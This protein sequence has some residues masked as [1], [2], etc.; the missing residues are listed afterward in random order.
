MWNGRVEHRAYHPV[1]PDTSAALPLLQSCVLGFGALDTFLGDATIRVAGGE[2]HMRYVIISLCVLATAC[3]GASP[4]APTASLGARS[5]APVTVAAGGTAT[6][7]AQ[8]GA[9]L[10]FK[11]DLTATELVEG[12]QHHLSGTGNGTHL[13]R[14]TYSAD[15]IVVEAT[16]DGTGTAVWTAAN[17]DRITANTSGVILEADF[18]HGRIVVGESQT[19]TG[20]TGRF[21]KASGTIRVERTLD[22]TS[23]AT[24]GHFDGTLSVAH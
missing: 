17:G 21:S 7:L 2:P 15:I 9:E 8:S 24:S 23:G 10:P 6:S 12:S 3:A 14:F 4:T 20:G 11:G 1:M 13:G 18:E 5:A 19:I 16:G 22:F